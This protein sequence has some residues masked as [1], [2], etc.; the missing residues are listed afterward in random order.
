MKGEFMLVLTKLRRN[1]TIDCLIGLDE[2]SMKRLEQYDPAQLI[3]PQLP[4][5]YR[6]RMPHS[7]SITFCS[8]ADQAEIRRM[9][10][11]DPE[12]EPKAFQKLTRGFEFHP[13]KGDHDMGPIVLGEKTEKPV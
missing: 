5:E 9:A 1:G 13:E 10:A 7:I 12:W 11:C 3:W 2:E 4:I 8:A 6:N